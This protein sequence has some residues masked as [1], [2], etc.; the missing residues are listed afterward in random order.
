[1]DRR[2]PLLAGVVLLAA[3]S[4]C[5]VILG[6]EGEAPTPT[7][8]PTAGAQSTTDTAAEPTATPGSAGTAG[9]TPTPTG[10]PAGD[11]RYESFDAAA[12]N[13]NHVAALEAAGSFTR[14]SSLVIRNESTTRFIN[15]SY[16]VERGGPYANT[17]NITFVVDGEP[18]DLPTTTR[19]TEGGTTYERQVER[20]GG[21]TETS[22]RK[23]SEPYADSDPQPVNETVAYTLGRIA[24]DVIDTSAWNRTGTGQLEGVDVTRYDTS[25]GRFA[26]S[27]APDARGAATVVVDDDGVIR[28]VTYRFVA[29]SGSERTEYVYEAAYTDVGS[30]TVEEPAWTDRA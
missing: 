4:G 24:R 20:T 19:Y 1:M 12:L 6:D 3:L 7:P 26:V 29:A 17:A 14:E 18:D 2:V 5:S 23:G 11:D 28:Y 9:G 30:T 21:G 25:G 27:M 15:G 8:E 16:A 13:A 22:Y 10:T